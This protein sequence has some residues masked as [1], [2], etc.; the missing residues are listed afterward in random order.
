M[1]NPSITQ[2]DV[3]DSQNDR[4]LIYEHGCLEAEPDPLSQLRYRTKILRARLY[5]P[6]VSSYKRVVLGFMP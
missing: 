1:A 6:T 3:T 2:P 5:E 4:S